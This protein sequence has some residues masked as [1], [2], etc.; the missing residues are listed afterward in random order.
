M[1]TKLH[2]GVP[3]PDQ[4]KSTSIESK[5][6]LILGGVAHRSSVRSRQANADHTLNAPLCSDNTCQDLIMRLVE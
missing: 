2:L 3:H 4:F 1:S 6:G 5:R